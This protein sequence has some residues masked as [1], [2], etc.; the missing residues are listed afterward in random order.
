MDIRSI[1]IGIDWQGRTNNEIEESIASSQKAIS[2][3]CR[4]NAVNCRTLRVCLSPVNTMEKASD[5]SIHSLVQWFSEVCSKNNIRWFCVPFTAFQGRPLDKCYNVALNIAR[6]YKNA[7]INFIVSQDGTINPQ[8]I[9]QVGEFIK[10]VSR[11]SNTG[12][13]NFRVGASCNCQAH[14][15]F[16][17]RMC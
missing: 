16:F 11:L 5:A 6:R 8:G 4:E 15:P 7:F 2:E 1:T 12:Y 13:D 9:M 3:L 17:C 10:D 14:T